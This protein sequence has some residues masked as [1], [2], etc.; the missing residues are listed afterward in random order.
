MTEK[1]LRLGAAGLG[2]AF[3]LMLPTLVLDP[4]ITI[5]AG[6]DPRT[7]ARALFE[8]DIGG[9]SYASVE[10]LCADPEID[11]VYISTPHQFHAA[12]ALAAAAHGKHIL[13]EKPMALSAAECLE[14]IEAARKAKVH[15]LVGHSHSYDGPVQ[16]ARAMIETGD[17]GEVRMLHALAGGA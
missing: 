4:R 2:R 13:C 1:K 10:E 5:V 6:A 3:S 16:Q 15:L 17:F 11:A 14:M 8:K 9:R 12:N 7:E